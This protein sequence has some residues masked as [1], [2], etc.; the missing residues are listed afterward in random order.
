MVPHY[1]QKV[2]EVGMLY[3]AGSTNTD[4]PLTFSPAVLCTNLQTKSVGIIPFIVS[5]KGKDFCLQ[6]F[7]KNLCVAA[8]SSVLSGICELMKE[9]L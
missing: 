5:V 9:L 7:Q 2:N 3:R 8:K 6:T 1:P 4:F